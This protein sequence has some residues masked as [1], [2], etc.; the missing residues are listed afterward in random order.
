[1][2]RPGAF[3]AHR[4]AGSRR[5]VPVVLFVACVVYLSLRGLVLHTNFDVVAIPSYELGAV[6]NIAQA[7]AVH[8]SSP[9]LHRFYD[10]CG[11]HLV[12]GVIAAQLYEW[13]GS[14][15]LTLK[16]APVGLGLLALVL[17]WF[18]AARHFGRGAAGLAVLAFAL[19]PPTLTKYSM[20][21]KGN[22]FENLPFQLLFL[23]L[24]L[25]CARRERARVVAVVTG[26]AGGFAIFV[27][28]GS[29]ALVAGAAVTFV[30]VRGL[31]RAATEIAL[32]GV[33][34][35][36][37][38]APLAW[39]DVVTSGRVRRFF[40]ANSATDV[41][42]LERL[43][44]QWSEFF[45]EI[46]PRA[47]T[48]APLGPI[49]AGA[50]EAVYLGAFV[51]A[52]GTLVVA[53][54]R[55]EPPAAPGSPLG[56]LRYRRGRFLPLVL[57]LPA[58][59]AILAASN[60][61][62]DEYGPA[63]NVGKFRY[64]VPHLAFATLVFGVAVSWL[65]ARPGACRAL[66]TAI[67]AVVL[68]LGASNVTMV[69]W[70]FARTA[71]GSRYPGF[72]ASFYGRTA[73][74]DVKR[75]SDGR[76]APDLASIEQVLDTLP[77]AARHLAQAEVAHLITIDLL[78]READPASKLAAVERRCMAA[79]GRASYVDVG[80]GIGAAFDTLYGGD[81]GRRHVVRLLEVIV[82]SKDVFK[83]VSNDVMG[84]YIVE[85]LSLGSRFV[86][87]R[88]TSTELWR[89]REK[90]GA[91][92]SQLRGGWHRGQGVLAGRILS[93]GIASDVEAVRAFVADVPEDGLDE[94]WFGVGFGLA[95]VGAEPD[96]ARAI[97]T[98]AAPPYA[99]IA[100]SG[101]GAALVHVFGPERARELHP[102][103]R[104]RVSPPLRAAFDEG[105]SWPSYPRPYV[106]PAR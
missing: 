99:W 85:G 9:P 35:A 104:E 20:L 65:R 100:T 88:R 29:I 92:P 84:G 71:L 60:F 80:R 86:L 61:N 102:E 73:L 54:T 82:R 34:F 97:E 105:A 32:A 63:V 6:G 46:L 70:T 66:G 40:T 15:Y 81:G 91:I 3:L 93:R 57:Y 101:A 4:D 75:D 45:G 18:V 83:D 51:V 98:L 5:R 16:L 28:I 69:D 31:R 30:L 7:R 106:P 25:E 74:R 17:I 72:D 10:N 47:G 36:I 33:G 78:L 76:L 55:R 8:E 96:V 14:S 50:L 38:I 27:Y 22:H 43:R 37:G 26:L 1:M 94:F 48:F 89:A 41:T 90:A 12:T 56:R 87:A 53:M 67:A 59:I 13:F 11:G 24:A 2:S 52:W 79:A 44:A 103:L 62:F 64:L 77:P 39:I 21:A 19:A 95:E 68:A 42:F 49:P 58:V 23:A